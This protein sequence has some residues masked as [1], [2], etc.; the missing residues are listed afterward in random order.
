M[1][2]KEENKDTFR[3]NTIDEYQWAEILE[4]YEVTKKCIK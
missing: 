2:L 1:Q 3:I 4:K